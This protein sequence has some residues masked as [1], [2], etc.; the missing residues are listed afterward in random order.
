MFPLLSNAGIF[1]VYRGFVNMWDDD[2]H[3]LRNAK[4]VWHNGTN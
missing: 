1:N 2:L 4:E 3:I